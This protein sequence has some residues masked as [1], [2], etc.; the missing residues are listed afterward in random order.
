[1]NE[2]T[3][4]KQ[5]CEYI[6]LQYPGV[7]FNSDLSGIKLTMGQAVQVKQLR[8]SR[9][10]PDLVIYEPR[11]PFHALFLELKADGVKLFRRDGFWKSDHLREQAD[12][13]SDLKKRGYH[14]DFAIGF[15]DAR[16]KIDWYLKPHDKQ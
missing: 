4:H 12:M 16:Q 10:F 1:M 3:I 13:I 8:S 7:I 5:V 2:K 15:D 14:A 6:R 11:E 9:A